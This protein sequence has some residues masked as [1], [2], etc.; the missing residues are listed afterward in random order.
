MTARRDLRRK[1][2]RRRLVV[3]GAVVVVAL[4]GAG[5]AVALAG[6]GDGTPTPRVAASRGTSSSTT[7]APSTTTSTT[8]PAP[9]TTAAPPPS[10]PSTAATPTAAPAPPSPLASVAGKTVVID[11]GHNGQNFAHPDIINRPV[12]IRTKVITCDTT[13]TATRDGYTESAY[14]L[15]VARRVQA[16]LAA[17]GARVVMTRTDDNGVGP[18]IDER[19]AIGNRARAAVG[20]SIHADGGP[21]SGRGFHVIYPPSIPNLTAPIAAAS[22]RLA[23]DLRAAYAYGTGMPFA[24]YVSSGNALSERSDLGGLNLSTVPKV[25]IETGNMQNAT[26]VALLENP[27]FRQRAAQAIA[28]GIAAYLAGR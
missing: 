27:A 6:A 7:T 22:L 14:N 2:T 4:A 8:L 20:V 10:P 18:C 24:T 12:D 28:D 25:F 1:R 11:P 13:G 5:F 17:A 23:L 19:A 15:D 21:V 9:S 26:D 3:A 16:I